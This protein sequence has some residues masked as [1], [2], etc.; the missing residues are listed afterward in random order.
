MAE[1]DAVANDVGVGVVDADAEAERGGLEVEQAARV[2]ASA[3]GRTR[4]MAV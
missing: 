4:F 1:G 3:R 2:S